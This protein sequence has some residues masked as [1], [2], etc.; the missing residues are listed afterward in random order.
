[1]VISLMARLTINY[2]D[3]Y[4]VTNSRNHI[5]MRQKPSYIWDGN[6]FSLGVTLRLGLEESGGGMVRVGPAHYNTV[7]E[8]EKFGEVL[9]KI[10]GVMN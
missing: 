5:T 6:Y 2:T 3:Y 8:I 4:Q 10:A 9:R 7:E 1:M